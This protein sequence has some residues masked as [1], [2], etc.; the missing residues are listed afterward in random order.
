MGCECF[1]Y[2]PQSGSD[3]RYQAVLEVQERVNNG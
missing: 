3:G 1:R 2:E